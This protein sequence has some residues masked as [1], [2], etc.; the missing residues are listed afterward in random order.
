MFSSKSSGGGGVAV[1]R[2]MSAIVPPGGDRG[3]QSRWRG[4]YSM[5]VRVTAAHD[6]P[7]DRRRVGR[8][9]VP[10]RFSC[11]NGHFVALDLT[12]PVCCG[13]PNARI[14]AQV[15]TLVVMHLRGR[16]AGL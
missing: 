7:R 6:R 3:V 11:P 10:D 5:I 1:R 4:A 2:A 16:I 14:W 12:R 13:E 9:P 15:G 8:Y